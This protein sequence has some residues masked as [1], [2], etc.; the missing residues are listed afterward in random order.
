MYQVPGKAKVAENSRF[1]KPHV[2]AWQLQRI[3]RDVTTSSTSSHRAIN[4]SVL[5]VKCCCCSVLVDLARKMYD[6]LETPCKIGQKK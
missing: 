5:V 4:R 6:D 3:S 1:K 2:V